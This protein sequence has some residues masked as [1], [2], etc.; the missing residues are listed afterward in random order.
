M[1]GLVCVCVCDDVDERKGKGGSRGGGKAI[2][3]FV[4]ILNQRSTEELS[5][6]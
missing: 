5:S 1:M 3:D 6:D 4:Y 2:I